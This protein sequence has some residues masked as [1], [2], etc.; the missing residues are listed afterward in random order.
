MSSGIP[1]GNYLLQRRIA[2]G[3]MAEVFLAV[4]QGPEGFQRKVAV[5][6]ILP[7]LADIPQFQEMF[8]DE[9]RLAA[10]LSHPNI[11]HIYEFG[12]FRENFYIAMEYIDGVDLGSVILQGLSS[13]LPLEH[14]A[15]IVAEVCAALNYAHQL[16]DSDDGTPLG[17]VH[18]D[19]S[20]QNIMVSFDGAVKVLDFGIAKAARHVERTQPGVVRG[21]FSYMSPEQV[22]GEQ[23]DG[24]SDL[25][26]AGI[27]LHE[28]C[29]AAPLF[30]RTDAVAAMQ[31]IRQ[32]KIPPP[33]REGSPLPAGLEAVIMRALEK[34]PN[35]RFA[36]AADMQ[37]ELEQFLVS[38][39]SLS[40][41]V[42]L[43]RY[44]TEHYRGVREQADHRAASEPLREAEVFATA[45]LEQAGPHLPRVEIL[46]N[47][48]DL[49]RRKGSHPGQT[50]PA[51]TEEL[52]DH[53]LNPVGEVHL[54]TA[55]GTRLL[56]LSSP[57]PGPP[58]P[59]LHQGTM[60]Q[61][62]P[63]PGPMGRRV[64]LVL[65]AALGLTVVVAGVAA[66][67][68]ISPSAVSHDQR[69]ALSPSH[70]KGGLN[71]ATPPESEPLGEANT[72]QDPL[73][74]PLEA[75]GQPDSQMVRLR[76]RDAAPERPPPPARQPQP[77]SRSPRVVSTS[78][79]AGST[80]ISAAEKS[81]GYLSVSTIPWTQVYLATGRLLGI[82]PL[83]RVSLPA[84][85]HKLLL[86]NPSGI[87]RVHR[88]TIRPGKVTRVR[89]KLQ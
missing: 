87:N 31:K 65:A 46:G 62:G 12:S 58:P 43:G 54:D 49:V 41:S 81:E 15:R 57:P 59:R 23:L 66:G 50:S 19:I 40:N 24:R 52:T 89:L 10:Q 64:L 20:P 88:V 63:S 3:G 38:S 74:Q 76:V 70:G 72:P 48:A 16:V 44:F 11:A 39:G 18:R 14:T 73:H 5:K 69:L 37:L 26:C 33:S 22:V 51:P 27:V 6:R 34:D 29:A 79:S 1:F 60:A 56:P 13:P 32:E 82:T 17:I 84:G 68:W 61:S 78:G 9:A 42:L 28:L 80:G 55:A 4:Q 71:S 2:R 25:F 36:N 77:R 8:L 86:K 21:K 47:T 30:P 83:A 7:H 53:D 35:D 45:G 67:Y 75:V 85:R